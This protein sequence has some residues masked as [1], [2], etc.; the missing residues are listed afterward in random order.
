MIL[1]PRHPTPGFFGA[2]TPDVLGVLS[3]LTPGCLMCRRMF[4]CGNSFFPHHA[5]P[6]AFAWP[7]HVFP[8]I[9][10]F[11]QD[12]DLW[13]IGLLASSPLPGIHP[14]IPGLSFI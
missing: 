5:V 6:F 8:P 9:N 1:T 4:T 14:G 3:Y 7:L 13:E 2:R 12:A 10:I 11:Q